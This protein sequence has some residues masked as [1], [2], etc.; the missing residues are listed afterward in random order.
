MNLHA[1]I[2]NDILPM[3]PAHPVKMAMEMF[4]GSTQTHVPIV[5]DR[6]F[7]GCLPENDIHS[8]D[9]AKRISD[10]TFALEYF[11]VGLQ[12]NWVD[13]LESFA[14]FNSNI[15]PVLDEQQ[16]YQGYYDLIDIVGLFKDTPFISEP[17]GILVVQKGVRD[18]S[19]S[20]VAQIVEG[21]DGR[22]LGVF[23]SRLEEEKVELTL[24][25]GNVGMNAISQTFRRYGYQIHSEVEG[26]VFIE[27]LK[28]RSGYLQ[29]Y[30]NI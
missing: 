3:T 22:L 2:N 4:A 29:K 12:S 20:E 28:Q 27:E 30:L 8:F 23:I 11:A 16:E 9:P 13:V 15:M 18:Y 26:D 14:R 7:L 6:K 10:Y 19:M 17:G 25:I 21:N 5:Q 24:K 1:Y